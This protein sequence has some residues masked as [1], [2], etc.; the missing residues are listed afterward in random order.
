MISNIRWRTEL[1]NGRLH[2]SL[3]E[4]KQ[5]QSEVDRGILSEHALDAFSLILHRHDL[6]THD[7]NL[8][9]DAF[10]K[11]RKVGVMFDKAVHILED[12]LGARNLT[13]E[14]IKIAVDREKAIV[15]EE[16]KPETQVVKQLKTT[17]EAGNAQLFNGV[18]AKC[19]CNI[20]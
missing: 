5:I 20:A 9:L 7:S 17:I 4:I 16:E 1:A 14:S 19:I 18:H 11:L 10:E 2:L 15:A 6:S 3:R 12:L 13:K 8:V